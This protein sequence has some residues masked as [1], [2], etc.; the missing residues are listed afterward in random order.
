MS[1]D[2]SRH[3]VHIIA[4][5]LALSIGWIVII[6]ILVLPC[7]DAQHSYAMSSQLSFD[8]VWRDWQRLVLVTFGLFF[9]LKFLTVMGAKAAISSFVKVTVDTAARCM[10]QS[11]S[12]KS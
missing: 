12:Q 5:A 9:G 2:R 7:I 6:P 3:G 10:Y 11:N 4:P 8:V 1:N